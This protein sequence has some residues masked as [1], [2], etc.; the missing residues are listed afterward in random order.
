MNLNLNN[1]SVNAYRVEITF[2][3]S[4]IY[5]FFPLSSSFSNPLFPIPSS[6]TLLQ[7]LGTLLFPLLALRLSCFSSYRHI[8]F[9]YFF[10]LPFLICFLHYPLLIFEPYISPLLFLNLSLFN[11]FLPLVFLCVHPSL[12][13]LS[14][15]FSGR[16]SVGWMSTTHP[17]GPSRCAT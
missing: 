15:F 16:R 17:S 6:L 10:I 3:L 9:I 1:L 7:C 14:I 11:L 5:P 8:F 4:A 13:F 2:F 12:L